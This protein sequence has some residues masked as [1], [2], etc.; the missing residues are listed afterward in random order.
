MDQWRRELAHA[1]QRGGVC[2]QTG[3]WQA[4]MG[5][6]LDLLDTWTKE[7]VEEVCERSGLYHVHQTG[8]DQDHRDTGRRDRR[9]TPYSMNSLAI[10]VRFCYFFLGFLRNFVRFRRKFPTKS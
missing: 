6:I 10:L 8:G 2:E 9:H 7:E 3:R 5:I 1:I 4:S